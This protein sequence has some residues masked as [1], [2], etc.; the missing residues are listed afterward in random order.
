MAALAHSAVVRPVEPDDYQRWDRF[1]RSHPEAT[2]YHLSAWARILAG[3]Y[4]FK[5]RYL[6][7]E[8][9]SGNLRGVLPLLS[10]RGLITGLRMRS[11][12]AVEIGGPLGADE[13][14]ERA[15]IEA[16]QSEAHRLRCPL[17]IDST[18]S[19]PAGQLGHFLNQV[20]RP[21][22]WIAEVPPADSYDA[23]LGDRSSNLR[24]GVKRARSRGVAVRVAESEEDLRRFYRVYLTTMRKHR[25][26]PRSLQQLSLARDLLGDVFRLFLAESDGRVVAGG[27]FHEFA[28]TLELLY[29]GSDDSALDLRPNHAL[30]AE[31]VRW[32]ADRNLS[33]FDHGYAWPGSS[34]ARFKQQWGG[35]QAP[36]YRYSSAGAAAGGGPGG[37]PGR[38]RARAAIERAW[39]STPLAL[40]RAAATI[41][42]RRL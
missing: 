41:A 12:P 33:R 10:R 21:P 31:A 34:L 23:W 16:A 13:A 11:L 2:V 25:S 42:Y 15:L 17:T 30:Y 27:V 4:R 18:R 36:R 7:V 19:L 8:D 39:G 14:A 32:A 6:V 9:E 26:L 22:C 38:S 3:A 1:V 35:E 40:T 20:P 5:P 37:S 24:R 29:N 28:G